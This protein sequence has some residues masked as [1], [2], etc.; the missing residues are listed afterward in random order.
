MVRVQEVII[1]RRLNIVRNQDG[2]SLISVVVAV[3]MMGMVGA[4]LSKYMTLG[5]QASESVKIK[6]ELNLLI[7]RVASSIN[8]DMTVGRPGSGAAC[9]GGPITLK[10]STGRSINLPTKMSKRAFQAQAFCNTVAGRPVG[11]HVRY[12]FLNGAK[13]PLTGKP[14]N[15]NTWNYF[16]DPNSSGF[17]LGSFTNATGGCLADEFLT[18]VTPDGQHICKKL[19]NA[20]PFL[21]NTS[22]P[23]NQELVGFRSDGSLRCRMPKVFSE[24]CP[25]GQYLRGFNSV[26]TKICEKLPDPPPPPPPPAAP[27]PP[28]DPP[29]RLIVSSGK[30]NCYTQGAF[31]SVTRTEETCNTGF[32]GSRC[33]CHFGITSESFNNCTYVV[34][35]RH[36]AE[37]GGCIAQKQAGN[38][39]R[40]TSHSHDHSNKQHFQCTF[41]CTK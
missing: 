6:S 19:R 3:G 37:A 10:N 34:T 17:C 22:C 9:T 35:N 7:N 12:R 11:I 32:G 25:S 27:P 26:G 31:S 39:W 29:K 41:T 24:L 4:V 30:R 13:D 8:C 20:K 38:K 28:P 21:Y 40:L 14:L 2:L 33:K 18:T 23:G 16:G 1:L 36:R 5:F 15:K